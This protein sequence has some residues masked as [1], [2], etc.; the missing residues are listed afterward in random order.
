MNVFGRVRLGYL[1]IETDKFAD[2]RRFGEDAIGMH[3]DELSRA[4]MRFR[5][6]D[7]ECRFL[8]RRG[9]EEDVTTIGWQLD[10]DETFDEI[11]SRVAGAGCLSSKAPTRKPRCVA[12]SDW[13]VSQGRKG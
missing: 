13:C 9:P 7:H 5:L 6:D 12:W 4:V 1:V 11:V 10:D 3:C 8:L 2:W